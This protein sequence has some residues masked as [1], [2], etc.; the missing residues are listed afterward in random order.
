MAIEDSILDVE[1]YVRPND[2]GGVTA[3]GEFNEAVVDFRLYAYPGNTGT[4]HPEGITFLPRRIIS[5]DA[6]PGPTNPNV[7]EK[8][9]IS[10]RVSNESL[11]AGAPLSYVYLNLDNGS[12]EI[13]PASRQLLLDDSAGD[14]MTFANLFLHGPRTLA[15]FMGEREANAKT[16]VDGIFMEGL[17]NSGQLASG[18]GVNLEPVPA[19]FPLLGAFSAWGPPG[20][21][22]AVS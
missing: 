11:A 16:L 4:L 15:E 9:E 12:L 1:N 14:P 3:M 8:F 21:C 10:L 2:L 6:G 20:G 22:G 19:P 13:N 18:Q 7:F 17:F 5:I